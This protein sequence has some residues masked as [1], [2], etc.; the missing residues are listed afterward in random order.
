MLDRMYNEGGV[1]YLQRLPQYFMIP[2]KP[3]QS[4]IS[5]R[6]LPLAANRTGV[7]GHDPR[8][9]YQ[10]YDDEFL[11]A[12]NP[13]E[14]KE[15]NPGEEPRE[16]HPARVPGR[17]SNVDQASNPDRE[18]QHDGE[19]NTRVAP[20]VSTRQTRNP[21]RDELNLQ[22]R[23]NITTGIAEGRSH[24]EEPLRRAN[25]SH[26][27]REIAQTPSDEEL[28]RMVGAHNRGIRRHFEEKDRLE[29]LI[30]N[31]RAGGAPRQARWAEV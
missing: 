4:G 29:A 8:G 21:I 20:P 28:E 10:A 18:D 25:Q 23:P 12:N 5:L 7:D 17:G 6:V 22:K 1:G 26:E 27:A 9:P 3:G 16:A 11:E 30:D 24:R 19:P 2:G 13:V 31:R 14:E 15:L